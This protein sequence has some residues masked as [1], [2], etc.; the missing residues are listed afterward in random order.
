DTNKH[1]TPEERA[2]WNK[3]YSLSPISGTN[4][5][6]LLKGGVP[7]GVSIDLTPY[8]D[9]TNL[10]R[11][12][13][14]T[15]DAN[16]VATFTRDDNTTFTVNLSSLAVNQVSIQDDNNNERFKLTDVLRFSDYFSFD[17]S[18]KK[19]SL[20]KDVLKTEL[21]TEFAEK[22]EIYQRWMVAH[23]ASSANSTWCKMATFQ[24]S[25]SPKALISFTGSAGFSQATAP[26]GGFMYVCKH[27]STSLN[28]KVVLNS[29]ED[30]PFDD[31]EVVDNGDNNLSVYVRLKAYTILEAACF[32]GVG[33]L[34]EY[35]TN[36]YENP[37]NGVSKPIHFNYHSGNLNNVDA[38]T[39]NGKDEHSFILLNNKKAVVSS[40]WDIINKTGLYT[41]QNNTVPTLP[42]NLDG[43]L[44]LHV[45]GG[46]SASQTCWRVGETKMWIRKSISGSWDPWVEI[47]HTGNSAPNRTIDTATT[48]TSAA[49]NNAFPIGKNPVNTTVTN[50]NN[51]QP[52]MYK[53]I[54]ATLWRSIALGSLI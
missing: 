37:V 35:H 18:N 51:S 43:L 42:E 45:D 2:V 48:Q 17:S 10:A 30:V 34:K 50:L 26:N 19:I 21:S 3:E 49:L 8:L 9:D 39:L 44:L 15:V 1:I 6:T 5:V 40:N 31:L 32:G 41:N 52:F 47:Y 12:V 16:G 54:T 20:D 4:K 22:E 27:S 46:S 11:L 33:F 13:S 28:V 7:I 38:V 25:G 23:N 24:N 29:D 14:G 36:V 53:R